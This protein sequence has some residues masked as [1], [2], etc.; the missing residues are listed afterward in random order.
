MSGWGRSFKKHGVYEKRPITK[1]WS[2]TERSRIGAK[3]VNGNTGDAENLEWRCR[4]LAKEVNMDK[5]EDLFV[6]TTPLE[7]NIVLSVSSKRS[8]MVGFH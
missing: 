2:K 7:A 5:C 3:W 6:A 8:D 1:C 4:L